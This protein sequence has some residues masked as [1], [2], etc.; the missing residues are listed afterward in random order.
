MV[1]TVQTRTTDITSSR[2]GAG[3]ADPPATYTI[4]PGDTLGRIAR[5]FGVDLG[6]LARIN[7]IRNPDRIF[8]GQTLQLPAANVVTVR[9]GD[10]L[11]GIAGR[12]GVSWQS[13]ARANSIANPELI[14]PGQQLRVPDTRTAPTAP[15]LAPA[16]SPAPAA[17][18]SPTPSGAPAPAVPTP[19]NTAPV[20]TAS[21]GSLAERYESAGRGPGTVSNGAG[22]PG[23]RSYGVHQLASR[24]GTLQAFLRTEGAPFADRLGPHGTARFDRE[25]QAI[26]RE[27]PAAFRDAQHAFIARTH[28]QPMV[29]AVTTR[30]G[31]DLTT[32]GRAVQEAAWSVSVQHGRAAQVMTDAIARADAVAQRGSPAYDRALVDAIYDARSDYVRRVAADPARTASERR[33][34]LSVVNNRYPAERADALA[35]LA[36]PAPAPAPS[37]AAAPAGGPVDG[38]AIA[39]REGVAIKSDAVRLDRL[40]PAMAPVIAAVAQA[41]RELGLPQAVITSGNDSVHS[42]G[43]LHYVDQALDFRG[44]DLTL[45]Q[46]RQ[47]AALVDRILGPGYDVVFETFANASNNHLH[48]EYDPR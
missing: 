34:L 10:T 42:T 28:Y 9:P 3:R 17:G 14:H 31:L 37:P 25:W 48:V 7:G 19:A 1:T 30:T 32:R 40:D 4:R 36:E 41:R 16:P 8:A 6:E 24:T 46:G 45:A 18:T 23:G 33:T 13:L 29:D 47:L 21:L 12:L 20:T 35:L 39:A 43:S 44:R 38:R 15:A 27:Q 11:S 26:A 5:R 22:D 2:A